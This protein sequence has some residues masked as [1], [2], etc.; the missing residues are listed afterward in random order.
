MSRTLETL[1]S[2]SVQRIHVSQ[3]MF[4]WWT[5]QVALARARAEKAALNKDKTSA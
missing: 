4:D 1:E 5:N 3:D 2:P